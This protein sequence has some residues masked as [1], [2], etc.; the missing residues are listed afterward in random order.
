MWLA[1]ESFYEYSLNQLLVLNIVLLSILMA[2]F[3]FKVMMTPKLPSIVF[4]YMDKK[5]RILLYIEH[6]CRYDYNLLNLLIYLLFL[7]SYLV[8]YNSA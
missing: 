7:V 3:V 4:E 6:V 2:H 1:F 5:T 8:P